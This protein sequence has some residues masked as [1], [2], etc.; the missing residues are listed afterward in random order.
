MGLIEATK[1]MGSTF[2]Y[3][4]SIWT[5]ALSDLV[6]RGGQTRE[7]FRVWK[8]EDNWGNIIKDSVAH[9]AMAQAP[10]NLETTEKN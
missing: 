10:L 5:E 7:G 6:M 8:K 4:E 3:S 2:Y 9:L 1:E